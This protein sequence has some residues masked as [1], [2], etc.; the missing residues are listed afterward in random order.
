MPCV[1]KYT[2][3]GGVRPFGIS[4][5]IIGF[6]ADGTPKLYQTEPSGTYSAWKVSG[7]RVRARMYRHTLLTTYGGC[8]RSCDTSAA[9]RSIPRAPVEGSIA[10]HG[11]RSVG[12]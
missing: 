6:D 2:Q 4:T 7:W 1:Q 10:M 3:S 8:S 9:E 11:L 5:L 12:T